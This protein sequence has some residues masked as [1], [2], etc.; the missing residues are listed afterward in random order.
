M[1]RI[2]KYAGRQSDQTSA[3]RYGFNDWA[4]EAFSFNGMPYRVFGETKADGPQIGQDGSSLITGVHYQ[5]PVVSAAVYARALLISQINFKWRDR[6]TREMFGN[7]GLAPLEAPQDGMSLPQLLAMAENHWSYHGNAYFYRP[8]PNT[9]ELLDPE[10]V[11]VVS[12]VDKT[13]GTSTPL[14]Y[15]V[16]KKRAGMGDPVLTIPAARVAHSPA[17]DLDPANKW[18]GRSWVSTLI[19]EITQDFQATEYVDAFYKNGAAPSLLI[20]VPSDFD[21]DQVNQFAELARKEYGGTSN[22]HKMMI[23]G[24][25]S[26]VHRLGSGINDLGLGESRGEFES[27]VAA[28]SRVPAVVLGVPTAAVIGGSALN[29]GNYTTTRRTWHDTWL[30]PTVQALCATLERI[31]AP[32]N[33]NTQLW[34]DTTDVAFVQEDRLDEAAIMQSKA[35]AILSFINAGYDPA[36]IIAAVD[37]NKLSLLTHTGLASVQLQPLGAGTGD[38]NV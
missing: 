23:I 16:F 34:F 19:R 25:G 6:S 9:I 38:N 35:G 28:R 24:N 33:S 2:D 27:R 12:E 31:V 26:D 15:L 10:K 17:L 32:P 30:N 8:D 36:T 5:H 21:E 20:G 7:A 37:A 14:E 29:A 22:A 3:K 18:F 4:N 11:A 1:R 13:I